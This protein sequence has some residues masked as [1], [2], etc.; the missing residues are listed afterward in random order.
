MTIQKLKLNLMGGGSLQASITP[1]STELMQK[2]NEVIDIVNTFTTQPTEEWPKRG[3]EYIHIKESSVSNKL[4]VCGAYWIN[5]QVDNY[6]LAK[7]NCYRTEKLAE[8]ALEKELKELN[9]K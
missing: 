4:F 5:S 2:I 7:K 9:L 3:D 8:E 6:R 1:S